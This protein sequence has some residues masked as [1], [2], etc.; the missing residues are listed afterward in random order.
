[1]IEAIGD[2]RYLVIPNIPGA[3]DRY[4]PPWRQRVVHS[5]PHTV[6][7]ICTVLY[8]RYGWGVGP[9]PSHKFWLKGVDKGL[10][11]VECQSRADCVIGGHVEIVSF[12]DSTKFDITRIGESVIILHPRKKPFEW[13]ARTKLEVR[14]EPDTRLPILLGCVEVVIVPRALCD[15]RTPVSVGVTRMGKVPLR[16]GDPGRQKKQY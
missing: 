7:N 11:R 1:M 2:R 14:I 9:L 16:E 3:I 8:N 6:V 15:T 5:A 13:N 10:I 12:I 4:G